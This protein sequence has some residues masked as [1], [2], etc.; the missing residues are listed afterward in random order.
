MICIQTVTKTLKKDVRDRRQ[1]TKPGKAPPQWPKL[2]S[3]IITAPRAHTV[4]EPKKQNKNSAK[5]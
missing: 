2:N 4:Q 1:I 5:V 3:H